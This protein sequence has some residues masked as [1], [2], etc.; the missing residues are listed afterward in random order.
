[1]HL[2]LMRHLHT[3]ALT[4]GF[5]QPVHSA[6][7]VFPAK[8]QVVSPTCS[9]AQSKAQMDHPREFHDYWWLFQLLLVLH[10]GSRLAEERK[11]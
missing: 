4:N 2:W 3:C 9:Y 10:Y 5:Q 11:R 1:M 7:S 6:P 8:A